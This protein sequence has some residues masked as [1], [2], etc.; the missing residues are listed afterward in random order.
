M[1]CLLAEFSEMNQ[2]GFECSLC[3][4]KKRKELAL[5]GNAVYI[6]EDV[7]FD[8]AVSFEVELPISRQSDIA[9]EVSNIILP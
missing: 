6:E 8:A 2:S 3:S 7:S 9:S 1:K 4:V 5:A